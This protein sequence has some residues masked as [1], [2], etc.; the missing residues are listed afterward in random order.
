MEIYPGWPKLSEH[1]IVYAALFNARDADGFNVSIIPKPH[2]NRITEMVR[3][4]MEQQAEGY[5]QKQFAGDNPFATTLSSIG[6]EFLEYC[7]SRSLDD[8]ALE[9][10]LFLIEGANLS[11]KSAG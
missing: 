9:R 4:C 5:L 11:A 10:V 3:G 8:A 7:R 1:P 6:P 2:R